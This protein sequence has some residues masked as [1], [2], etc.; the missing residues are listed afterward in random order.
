[1]SLINYRVVFC[2]ALLGLSSC[3]VP[4]E[5]VPLVAGDSA[6]VSL[7]QQGTSQVRQALQWGDPLLAHEV[8]SPL[9]LQSMYKKMVGDFKTQKVFS[10]T[11]DDIEFNKP[12]QGQATVIFEVQA[13]GSPSY[14]VR[15]LKSKTIWE[16]AR[17]NKNG[18]MLVG[19][20]EW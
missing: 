18:W 16:F 7:L 12:K 1:M 10:V 6:K 20:E 11:S 15:T 5:L 17:T 8:V 13:Y 3:T 14:S 4:R 2:F 9:L 19:I